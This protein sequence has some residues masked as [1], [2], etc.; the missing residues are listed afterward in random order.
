MGRQRV[1]TS[2]VAG[3]VLH[4]IASLVHEYRVAATMT[5][6]EV[7]AR[8]GVSTRTVASIEAGSPSTAIGNVLNVAIAVGL[9]LF[10]T[11]DPDEHARM[12]VRSA[13]RTALLPKRVRTPARDTDGLD[14]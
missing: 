7:A 13:E 6:A 11:E 10:S 4:T 2:I 8:A 3:H 9:P 5:Q 14:F 1:S 12:R